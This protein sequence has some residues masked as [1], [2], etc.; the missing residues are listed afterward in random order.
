MKRKFSHWAKLLLTALAMGVFVWHEMKSPMAFL[1][2]PL[3]LYGRHQWLK[4]VDQVD[5]DENVKWLYDHGRLW[6]QKL[7]PTLNPKKCGECRRGV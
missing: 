7:H 2:I 1:V 5:R 6:G 3:A 4:V